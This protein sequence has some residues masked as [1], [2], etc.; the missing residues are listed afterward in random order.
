[1]SG[2]MIYTMGLALTRAADFGLAVSVLVEGQWMHGQ[3]AAHDGT[4]L[5]LE[6]PD[7]T[8]SVVRV[9]RIAAVNLQASSPFAAHD[10]AGAE[11][12]RPLVATAC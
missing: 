3:V 4:G 6:Q 7:G 11:R 8:H 1:M 5:V 9:E 10:Q 2:S 12:A